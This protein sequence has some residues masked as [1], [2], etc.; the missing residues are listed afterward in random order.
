MCLFFWKLKPLSIKWFVEGQKINHLISVKNK[1]TSWLCVGWVNHILELP[2]YTGEYPVWFVFIA[3]FS[4]LTVFG[5]LIFGLVTITSANFTNI[6]TDKENNAV[7][8]SALCNMYNHEVV[9]RAAFGSWGGK[10]FTESPLLPP[11]EKIKLQWKRQKF[12]TWG[13][14]R[15]DPAKQSRFG[16]WGGKRSGGVNSQ[17]SNFHPNPQESGSVW[18]RLPI[19][20]STQLNLKP[21]SEDVSLDNNTEEIYPV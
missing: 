10:R 16:S 3:Y 5:L 9:Q 6:C 2:V 17:Y 20:R 19:W 13:G 1:N 12:G 7:I 11:E 8:I 21:G 18:N 4:M 15:S 14:K